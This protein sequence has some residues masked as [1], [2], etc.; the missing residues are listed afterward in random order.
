MEDQALMAGII[1]FYHMVLRLPP[2]PSLIAGDGE[3]DLVDRSVRGGLQP[4]LAPLSGVVLIFE[5]FFVQNNLT[6]LAF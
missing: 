1:V 6:I 5:E 2:A 4:V 3:L